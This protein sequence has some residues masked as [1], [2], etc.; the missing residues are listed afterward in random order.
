MLAATSTTVAPR[1]ATAIAAK[2]ARADARSTSHIP[3]NARASQVT[4]FSA[5]GARGD[6]GSVVS[7]CRIVNRSGRDRHKWGQHESTH[8]APSSPS[9]YADALATVLRNSPSPVLFSA[10][11]TTVAI[12]SASTAAFPVALHISAA[13][14]VRLDPIGTRRWRTRPV[15][16]APPVVVA[17]RI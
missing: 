5:A 14:V 17:L 7:A 8:A 15:P 16:V 3:S 9:V 2:R 13:V 11:V 1:T 4:T 12:P 10:P 6:D